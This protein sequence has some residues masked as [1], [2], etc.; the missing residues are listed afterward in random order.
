MDKRSLSVALF[1]LSLSCL[2]FASYVL[3]TTRVGHA[4]A[5]RASLES[6]E[7][8][9]QPTEWVGFSAEVTIT[10]PDN[11]SPT[12]GRFYRDA[13]GCG[14]LDTGPNGQTGVISIQTFRETSTTVGAAALV[15]G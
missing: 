2:L 6:A 4:A 5:T 13:H 15:N 10:H 14:R 1:T 11:H 9:D 8:I 3:I 7:V 12:Y